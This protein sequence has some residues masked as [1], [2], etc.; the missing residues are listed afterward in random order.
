M[1]KKPLTII[2]KDYIKLYLADLQRNKG[3]IDPIDLQF[4]AEKIDK[5][6]ELVKNFANR[7]PEVIQT[8]ETPVEKKPQLTDM[9][10][11]I[12]STII[13]ETASKKQSVAVMSEGASVLIEEQKKV[14][15]RPSGGKYDR[16]IYRGNK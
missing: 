15:S 2:E 9:Q 12:R 7:Q 5:P 16:A 13:N 8:P 10:K 3:R 1:N 6:L 4:L 14:Q 11:N